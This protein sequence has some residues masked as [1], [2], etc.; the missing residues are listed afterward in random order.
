[1]EREETNALKISWS[2]SFQQRKEGLIAVEKPT[3]LS[4]T[5][6]AEH[7]TK[8]ST[9]WKTPWPRKYGWLHLHS[10]I[11]IICVCKFQWNNLLSVGQSN[12]NWS[13]CP[14]NVKR[15]GRNIRRRV[16][17][18]F[19]KRRKLL[20]WEGTTDSSLWVVGRL[21]CNAGLVEPN[22]QLLLLGDD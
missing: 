7:D 15:N 19:C 11:E 14:H 4:K 9:K 6:E 22:W 16:I 3:E 2:C 5:W 8:P 10:P 21:G 20:L 18:L 17:V 12:Y 1:M 13:W